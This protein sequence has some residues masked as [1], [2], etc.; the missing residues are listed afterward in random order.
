MWPAR[1]SKGIWRMSVDFCLVVVVVI[2][3]VQVG[4][5]S[6]V[7]CGSGVRDEDKGDIAVASVDVVASRLVLSVDITLV[8]GYSEKKGKE[9]EEMKKE[10]E[11]KSHSYP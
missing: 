9:I 8:L 10:T 2:V 3:G 11:K 1:I 6:K 7:A 4:G 5:G